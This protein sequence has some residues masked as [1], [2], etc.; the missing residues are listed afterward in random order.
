MKLTIENVEYIL[1]QSLFP[2]GTE[3]TG[4][5]IIINGIVVRFGFDPT[6][7]KGQEKNI[8][9]LLEQLPDA[10]HADK[11]GGMSFLKACMDKNGRQWGEQKTMEALFCL[12]MAIG[13]VKECLPRSMWNMLPGGVPYYVVTKGGDNA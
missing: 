5:A 10:F 4:S 6:R 12:G 1:Q 7:V 3:D 9:S 13:H 11:G 2:E 8:V